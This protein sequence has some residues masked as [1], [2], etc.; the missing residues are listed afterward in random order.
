MHYKNLYRIMLVPAIAVLL[1]SCE[2]S[3]GTG[4]PVPAAVIPEGLKDCEFYR[5]TSSMGTTI[6]VVRCPNSSTAAARIG[7]HPVYSSTV[8]VPAPAASD[9]NYVSA[10]DQRRA[11]HDALIAKIDAEIKRL[12]LKAAEL[13]AESL[14]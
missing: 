8:E 6:H 12:E 5:I 10:E 14:K 3:S 4:A 7:K 11:L 13:R 1:A 9:N 2:A